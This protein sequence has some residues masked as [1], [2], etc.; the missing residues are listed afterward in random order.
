MRDVRLLAEPFNPAETLAQFAR[1]CAGWGGLASFV[2]QVRGEDAVDALEFTYYPPLTLSGMEEL[3]DAALQRF[4]I[5][6]VLIAHR[7]GT[8]GPGE[9]IVC[10]AAAARHRR[11]AFAAVDFAMDHLKCAAWLWKRERRGGEWRWVEPRAD[12]HSDLARWK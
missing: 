2:G 1:A 10:V 12:D 6:G 3:A 4:A 9:P 5:Q 8:L 7:V 11:G